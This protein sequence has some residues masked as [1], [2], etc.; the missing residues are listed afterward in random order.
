MKDSVLLMHNNDAAGIEMQHQLEDEG[1]QVR[2]SSNVE[3]TA[4]E[5]A[6]DMPGILLVQVK[7]DGRELY[8]QMDRLAEYFSFP[9][10][11]M[12]E[13]WSSEELIAALEAGVTEVIE[14]AIPFVELVARIRSLIRLFG[15]F[16]EGY[17]AELNYEDLKIEIKGRKTYR[18]DELIKLT[19][20]EFDLL[21]YLVKRAEQ[22]CQ[23]EQILQEVWG[24]D[25]AT[26]TN[27]VDVYIRHLRKKID[28]GRTRKLIHTVRGTG[29]MIH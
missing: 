1:F 25:F 21:R 20:K 26:G 13:E 8:A 10:L 17:V 27:V 4:A 14:A 2:R 12:L 3:D 15:R 9:V 11:M 6:K 18:G 28:K 5:L 24:Y 7:K 19:P 23:R 29:Y 22:V 16:A